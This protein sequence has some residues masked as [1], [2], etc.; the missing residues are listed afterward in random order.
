MIQLTCFLAVAETGSFTAAGRRLGMTTSGVSKTISRLEQARAIRLLNRSTHAVSLTEDGERLLPLA[1]EAL[2]GIEK[3]DA[4]ISVASRDSVAGRVRITAPT[5]ILTTCLVPLL[6]QFRAEL[7]QIE[8]DLR[9]S[10]RMV[11]LA[12]EAIDLAIRTGPL[13]GIPGHRAQILCDFPWITCAAPNYL[14]R[15]GTPSVPNDLESHDLIGFRSQ[16]T[17][18]VE[19]WRYAHPRTGAS[20]I[21]RISPGLAVVLDDACAVAAAAVSGIGIA[22]VPSRLISLPLRAGALVPLLSDWAGKPMRMSIV[23]REGRVS[24]RTRIVMEFLRTNRTA[25]A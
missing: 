9:G 7:P 2:R 24:E 15:R 16:R 20:K 18:I 3:A 11:D 4:A 19:P 12:E 21:I 22:W 13:D 14:G 25:F 8:L 10:D 17:G 1:R 6:P 5:A 23:R